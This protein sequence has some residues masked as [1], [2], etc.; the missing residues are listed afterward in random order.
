MAINRH[1]DIVKG[2]WS[3]GI[4]THNDK[5]ETLLEKEKLEKQSNGV[6]FNEHGDAVYACSS[7]I[8]L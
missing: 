5:I 7:Y 1:I 2:G 8:W 4:I 6:E 3:W